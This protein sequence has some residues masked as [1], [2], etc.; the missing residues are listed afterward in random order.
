MDIVKLSIPSDSNPSASVQYLHSVYKLL[1]NLTELEIAKG[2]PVP[3]LQE[4]LSSNAF[5]S[6]LL[7]T[8]LQQI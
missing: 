3:D 7:E 4:Y 1:V 8:K 5:L 2:R 6:S